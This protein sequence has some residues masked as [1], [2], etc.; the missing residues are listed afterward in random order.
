VSAASPEHAGHW[1]AAAGY[2]AHDRALLVALW[3]YARTARLSELYYGARGASLSFWMLVIDI[4][5]AVTASGSGIAGLEAFKNGPGAGI[6]PYLAALTA[7]LAIA[8]P[9][10][11]LDRKARHATQQQSSYRRLLAG[12]EDLAFDIEQAG[13]LSA[14]HRQRFQ[15]ARNVLRQAEAQDDCAVSAATLKPLQARVIAEMP[16]NR[17]WVPGPHYTGAAA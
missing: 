11:A 13:E 8:K 7:F 15:R 17:L 5:I 14:E 3:D 6:W 16:A 12:L 4:A 1:P 10:L 9:L 2:T